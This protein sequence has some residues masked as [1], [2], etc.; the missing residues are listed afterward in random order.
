MLRRTTFVA[1]VALLAGPFAVA[2]SQVGFGV[3]AGLSAP[4]GNFGDAVE[5]GY[6]LTGIVNLA[7]PLAP[8]GFRFEG[9]YNSFNYQSSL[10]SA[11]SGAS[12]RILSGTANVVF[13]TP[14]LLGP[15]L[16]GGIG[17]YNT[18][19]QCSSCNS[20]S[21]NLGFNGGVG[22][23]L[24]LAGFSAFA[25]ARLHRVSGSGAGSGSLMYVPVSVGLT[26]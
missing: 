5:S 20:S 3:A 17:A 26:F 23:K 18:S 12:S 2:E 11:A 8:V 21:T 10:S 16:I 14:G 25:E 4:I 9:S 24:G 7:I 1:V 13:S 6:H 19:A 15:Y 22:M